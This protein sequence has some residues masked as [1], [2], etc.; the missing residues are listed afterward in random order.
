MK[1]W[2]QDPVH[3]KCGLSSRCYAL[4]SEWGKQLSRDGAKAKCSTILDT[5]SPVLPLIL[6][7][8]PWTP[9]S[10]S[11]ASRPI[12]SAPLC[13]ES[14]LTTQI[15][16]S[17]TCLI[18]SIRPCHLSAHSPVRWVGGKRGASRAEEARACFLGEGGWKKGRDNVAIQG[19]WDLRQGGREMNVWV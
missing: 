14:A 8:P 10:S 12:L 6:Q 9:R 4:N 19:G 17:C 3:H 7:E 18:C 13:L 16:S 1:S 15:T 11:S 2:V 5:M